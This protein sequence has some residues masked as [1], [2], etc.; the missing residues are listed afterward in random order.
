ML[1]RL[2]RLLIDDETAGPPPSAFFAI[3]HLLDRW[4]LMRRRIGVGSEG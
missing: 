2:Q 1:W 4:S 3:A